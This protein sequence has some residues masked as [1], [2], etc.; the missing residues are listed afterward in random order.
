M[1]GLR[2]FKRCVSFGGV[3]SSAE[4]PFYFSHASV[5]AETKAKHAVA[6]Q[7]SKGLV[8][9]SIG[10]EHAD[11]LIDDLRAGLERAELA[12]REAQDR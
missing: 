5:D 2:L 7:V 4:L 3:Q 11:D 1:D 12:A 10:V 6:G 9:L 8:R